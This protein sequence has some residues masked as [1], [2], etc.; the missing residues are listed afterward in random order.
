MI[1]GDGSGKPAEPARAAASAPDGL[2]GNDPRLPPP[3][4]ARARPDD[5]P[6]RGPDVTTAGS[7]EEESAG[8]PRLLRAYELFVIVPALGYLIF[9]VLRDPSSFLDPKIV[10][11]T[12]AIAV[13]DL[14]PVTVGEEL[15]LSLS[16]PIELA[17]AMLFPPPVAMLITLAGSF[18]PREFRG[19][20][21]LLKAVFIRAQVALSILAESAVFHSLAQVG[22]P[23]Y[24]LAPAVVTAITL[25]YAVN[26]L[27][28]AIYVH[29]ASGST[30][31]QIIDRMKVGRASEFL[32]SY[33]GL[34]LF[35][36]VIAWVSVNDGLW[37]VVVFVA[38]LAFGR[39][40]Y[41]KSRALSDRLAKQNEILA[42]QAAKLREHLDRE[43]QAV[44]EL[45]ELNR[46]K[47]E[48]AAVA[49]HELRTPLTAI[50]GYAKT[51]RQPAFAEDPVMREEFLVAMERQGDRLL[52]LVENL[53]I[54]SN[55]ENSQIAVHPE[56]VSLEDLCRELIEG[57][58]RMAPR[59]QLDL[60]QLPTLLTDRQLLGRVLANLL[61]NALKYSPE[62]MPCE[63]G[64]IVRGSG[65]DIWVRDYGVGISPEDQSKIFERFY[66]A[67]SSAT[68]TTSGV[69]LGLS[70]VK[71]IVAALGGGIDV[72]SQPGK[73]S[74][75]IVTLPITYATQV[76]VPDD[77]DIDVARSA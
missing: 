36:M 60:P 10:F 31:R 61:D 73:G 47:S 3:K 30:M 55:L 9:A 32:V 23:W 1:V 29:L 12:L 70:L 39:Q 43:Q 50:I 58:G 15:Q 5:G 64:A 66:Q 56:R 26:V 2:P 45:R 20:L 14:M 25:G 54:A 34:S 33:T 67:D 41:F 49:S 77:D 4:R 13:V 27:L 48:F 62:S 65:M 16:F 42:E 21:P 22:D 18:D 24:W 6:A 35:G 8:S 19:E 38:P 68:R 37:L 28:V 52:R 51:L 59:V 72:Q 71:E 11:W 74:R 63:I 40:M 46:M 75:F 69:G 7:A 76:T 57:L 17:V 53:L 44:A